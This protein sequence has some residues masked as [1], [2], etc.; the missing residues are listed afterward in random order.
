MIKTAVIIA[1]TI[2]LLLGGLFFYAGLFDPIELTREPQ[3]PYA[4]VYRE[5]RGPYN[6]IRI[7]MNDVYRYV[8]DTLQLPTNTGFSVFYDNPQSGATDTL[9]SIGGIVTDS[10]VSVRKPYRSGMF[11]RTDAV[12]GRFRIRSFF[13]YTT[14]AY[15]FYS[16]LQRFLSEKKIEQTGPVMETYDMVKRTITFIAPVQRTISPVPP[17]TGDK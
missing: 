13:S 17:F 3:G 5:Y 16:E 11:D 12:V 4:L 10:L 9:R 7:V 6:G 8:R 1:S 2:L 14:G 15:K